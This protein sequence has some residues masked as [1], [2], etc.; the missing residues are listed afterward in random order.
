[1]WLWLKLSFS[2]FCYLTANRTSRCRSQAAS[3]RKKP[4]SRSAQPCTT[5]LLCKHSA[6]ECARRRSLFVTSKGYLGTGPICTQVDDR[7]FL[8]A[9][10]PVPLILR[11]HGDSSETS[12]HKLAGPA[13]KTTKT[14]VS[15]T[16]EEV[17][18]RVLVIKPYSSDGMSPLQR[19][20]HS[21]VPWA[22]RLWY[23]ASQGLYYS[24]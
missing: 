21:T 20:K 5:R 3:R 10:V 11:P 23:I 22:L 9:G 1:M 24:P 2:K 17:T 8:I 12:Q 16:T 18:C 13:F 19:N 6:W 14:I 4:P 15:I 7:V